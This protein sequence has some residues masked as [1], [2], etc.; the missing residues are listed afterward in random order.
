MSCYLLI[1]HDKGFHFSLSLS[2]FFFFFNLNKPSFLI[3]SIQNLGTNM[4]TVQLTD[5]VLEAG[6]KSDLIDYF[7]KLKLW[8]TYTKHLRFWYEYA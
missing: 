2:L 1:Q 8:D 7:G 4:V 3:S 6:C 5:Y